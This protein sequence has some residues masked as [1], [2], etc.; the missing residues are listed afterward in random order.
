MGKVN[1]M[2]ERRQDSMVI[3]KIDFEIRQ[4]EIPTMAEF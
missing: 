4:P 3:Q 1:K 2:S